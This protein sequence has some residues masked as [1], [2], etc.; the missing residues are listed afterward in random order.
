MLQQSTLD[1]VAQSSPLIS[2]RRIPININIAYYSH[3][4][5]SSQVHDTL[6]KTPLLSQ[7]SKVEIILGVIGI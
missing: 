5:G 2:Q 3:R 4:S 1:G 6:P 7:F